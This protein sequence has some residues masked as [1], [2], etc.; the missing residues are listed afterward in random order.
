MAD[1]LEMP[2]YKC[3]CHSDPAVAGEESLIISASSALAAREN[4]PEMFRSAQ[5]DSLLY[6]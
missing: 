4:N 3:S 5:H 6:V 2:S 1:E